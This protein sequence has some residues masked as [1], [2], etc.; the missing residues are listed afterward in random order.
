MMDR[1]RAELILTDVLAGESSAQDLD[2]LY[3][4]ESDNTYFSKYR[5]SL[6]IVWGLGSS[7][8]FNPYTGSEI[9]ISRLNSIASNAVASRRK[10]VKL[11]LDSLDL[12]SAAGADTLDVDNDIEK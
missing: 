8:G 2:E 4:Y 3:R 5:E 11:S 10:G 12:L 6:E 7:E 9:F 1:A